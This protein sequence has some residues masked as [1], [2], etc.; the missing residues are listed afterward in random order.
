[1]QLKQFYT[2]DFSHESK[3]LKEFPDSASGPI[4]KKHVTTFHYTQLPAGQNT[5]KKFAFTLNRNN[6]VTV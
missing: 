5:P 3:K 6:S 2:S 1:L 4:K